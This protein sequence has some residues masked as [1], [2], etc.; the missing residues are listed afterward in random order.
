[1]LVPEGLKPSP[2]ITNFYLLSLFCQGT[3]K[4]SKNVRETVRPIKTPLRFSDWQSELNV[5]GGLE[6]RKK[7]RTVLY[8]TVQA[9]DIELSAAANMSF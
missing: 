3:R 6:N 5:Q 9:D 7:N 1:M 8:S 4:S 2:A